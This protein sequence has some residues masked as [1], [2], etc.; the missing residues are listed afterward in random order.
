MHASDDWRV[1]SLCIRN[2]RNLTD[3][4]I[5][6]DSSVTLLVG[7]NGSGKTTVLDALAVMLSTVVSELGGE[8]R[9]FAHSDVRQVISDLSSSKRTATS[10]AQY[11]LTGQLSALVAGRPIQWGRELRS[12]RGRTTPGDSNIVNYTRA[13]LSEA[14]GS[15]DARQVEPILPV[16]GYYGVERLAG[17]RKDQGKIPSSRTG[18]YVSALDPRSDLNRLSSFLEALD[19]QV[20]AAKAYGDETPNAAIEQL[21]AIDAAC[22]SILEPVGWGNLRWNRGINSL[23]LSHPDQG[24]LPL[25]SLASGARITAGLAIDLASRMARANPHLGAQELLDVT[26]GIVLID[27]IDLHLHPTWQQQIVPA[28]R[29]TFPRVQFILSTH[30]PQ[31]IATVE[32]ENIRILRGSS[33]QIPAF[34]L[35]L[36]PEAI[37]SEVQGTNP[38]PEVPV[39][40]KL[41]EYLQ[42]VYA[43]EGKGPEASRLRMEIDRVMG[44]ASRNRELVEAD[45]YLAFSELED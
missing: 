35:G 2:F 17:L 5:N 27:E 22:T 28:L 26:P 20:L 18:A 41:G 25:T 6:F 30:S 19:G 7:V 29:R 33:V 21:R 24:T 36:R 12:P 40:K 43:G 31:V 10:E 3:L 44:G 32:T 15:Q 42:V 45:A 13:I 34:A 11:P 1:D 8:S 38:T 23:T 39:R 16:L 14:T 37:L 4:E 9:S